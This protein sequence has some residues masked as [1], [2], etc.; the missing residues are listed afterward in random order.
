MNKPRATAAALFAKA[1]SRVSPKQ[2]VNP[3][4][5]LRLMKQI[6]E[7][8]DRVEALEQILAITV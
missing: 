5:E 1:K 2:Q 8:K 7:L 4:T 3:T 6:Q